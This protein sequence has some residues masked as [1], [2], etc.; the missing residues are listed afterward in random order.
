MTTPHPTQ[1]ALATATQSI[2]ADAAQAAAHQFFSSYSNGQ[3]AFAWAL[4][5]PSD[6]RAV[7][8]ATWVAVHDG[9]PDAV[10][11]LAYRISGVTVTESTAIVRYT[12]AV[13]TQLTLGSGIQTFAYSG[14]HWRLLLSDLDVYQHGSVK[15]DIVAARVH[16]NCL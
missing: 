14:N 13:G 12:I 15:A 6:Q 7:P 11:G 2:S 4:L 10:A 9:C 5:D 16:Q 3:Y 8:Q 1:P